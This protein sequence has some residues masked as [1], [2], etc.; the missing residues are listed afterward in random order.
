MNTLRLVH[1]ADW[2]LS[3]KPKLQKR[4]IKNLLQLSDYVKNNNIDGI[5]IAGDI[6]DRLQQYGNNSA[7]KIAY[8]FL[9]ELSDNVKFI[10]I[11]K[12]NSSHDAIQSIELLHQYRPN[13]YAFEKN[14][15]SG[16]ILEENVV[17][18][19]LLQEQPN[20]NYDLIIHG[21]SYPTK[22]QLIN[23]NSIDLQNDDFMRC[24]ENLLSYHG[25]I[26]SSYSSVPKITLFH[27]NV[28]GARLSN[29]QTLVGQDLIVPSFILEK[30]L[31]DYY[32]LGHIH[33]PQNITSNIRYSGSL[34]NK[35]FG[36]TEEKSFDVLEFQKNELTVSTIKFNGNRPL[37]VV[38]AEFAGGEF[39]YDKNIPDEAE[40]KFRYRINESERNLLSQN[41][42]EEI[43]RTLGPDTVFE[44]IIIPAERNTRT[45]KIMHA[46]T[47]LEE[48]EEYLLVIGENLSPGII[49][50]V[51][52]LEKEISGGSV[53]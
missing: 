45:S 14:V 53:E 35:D 9:S 32:A 42:I 15:S 48:L 19:D 49:E 34:Y 2:H 28:S 38:D 8:E 36:E 51:E 33:L 12:G 25:T 37:V 13:I 39:I 31:S 7:I 22:A 6:W 21:I 50:K 11:I 24:F 3:E 29:G 4:A 46:K 5:L 23:S 18:D 40:I 20:K 1:T 10:Y 43:R 17:I 26:S 27:G 52:L 41:H 16:I 47:I 44:S 30:T